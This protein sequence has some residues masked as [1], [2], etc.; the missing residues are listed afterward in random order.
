MNKG[1]NENLKN[2]NRDGEESLGE[3]RF[4]GFGPEPFE[5]LLNAAKR[6]RTE[7]GPLKGAEIGL[8][9]AADGVESEN[10]EGEAGV[11]HGDVKGEADLRVAG[12]GGIG[13]ELR[14]GF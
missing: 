3:A 14:R 13:I 9:E 1:P 4:E 10:G 8:E 11:G 6:D 2:R 7:D 5:G 12:K